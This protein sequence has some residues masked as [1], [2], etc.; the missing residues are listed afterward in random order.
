MQGLD[1]FLFA[2]KAA[3]MSKFLWAV[4]F[5]LALDVLIFRTSF[6]GRFIRPDSAAGTLLMRCRLAE[7]MK[8]SKDQLV[9]VLGDSRMREGFS[10]KIFDELA[11]P[12]PL[13]ALNL[14]VSGS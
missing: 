11:S 5:L 1:K 4:I 6:Y 14:T 9:A 3:G 7:K 2:T 13:K 10:A 12:K 8:A